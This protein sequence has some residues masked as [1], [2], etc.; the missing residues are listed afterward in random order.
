MQAAIEVTFVAEPGSES[1]TASLVR[2]Q[3]IPDPSLQIPPNPT[4][5]SN[6]DFFLTSSLPLFTLC[7]L[8]KGL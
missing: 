1:Q 4:K 8:Q 7:L 5:R 2:V 3:F 6:P